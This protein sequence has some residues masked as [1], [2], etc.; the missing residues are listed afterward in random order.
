M[1][2]NLDKKLEFIELMDEMK[3]IKRAIYLKN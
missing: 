2:K 3:N 1:L